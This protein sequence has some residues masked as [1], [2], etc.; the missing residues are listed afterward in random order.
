[1]PV[2][3][4][5]DLADAVPDVR[6]V[7]QPGKAPA[8]KHDLRVA[9]RSSAV[10]LTEHA[11]RL[12]A[13]SDLGASAGGVEVERAQLLIDLSGGDAERLHARRVELDAYLT[14]DAAATRHLRHA[15]DG[16]QSLGDGV[17]HEPRQILVRE[18]PGEQADEQQRCQCARRLDRARSLLRAGRG[19]RAAVRADAARGTVKALDVK[20]TCS[21]WPL[22]ALTSNS[23]LQPTRFP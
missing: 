13:A 10:G 7:R 18:P 14:A 22:G 12:L 19:S 8:G 16:Q 3:R 9:E 23:G 5:A 20:V 21:S 2:S 1:M 6:Q 15:L 17:V 4:R 11:D